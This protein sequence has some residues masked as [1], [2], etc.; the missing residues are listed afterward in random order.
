MIKHYLNRLFFTLL[1]ALIGL[2]ILGGCDSGKTVVDE[3]TGNRAVKQYH[4]SKKDL[5][6]ISDKQSERYKKM[7]EDEEEEG[8]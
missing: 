6:E 4:K 8:D 3:V 1:S 5:D 7:E 2:F